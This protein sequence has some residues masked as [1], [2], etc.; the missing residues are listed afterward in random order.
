MPLQ[1]RYLCIVVGRDNARVHL[2]EA[3]DRDYGT[4]GLALRENSTL[5]LSD[6]TKIINLINLTDPKR[7]T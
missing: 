3:T 7:V 6:T 4:Y 2:Q 5:R 1:M